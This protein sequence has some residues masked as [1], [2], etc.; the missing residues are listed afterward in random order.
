MCWILLVVH[1]VWAVGKS[2]TP[3]KAN[4]VEKRNY[5]KIYFAQRCTWA[6]HQRNF[7]DSSSFP[8]LPH[9]SP[10]AIQMMNLTYSPP[11]GYHLLVFWRSNLQPFEKWNNKEISRI[12]S[13][14]GAFLIPRGVGVLYRSY[15]FDLI[16]SPIWPRSVGRDRNN[17][18]FWVAGGEHPRN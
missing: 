10:N 12:R 6:R 7:E 14:L 13:N 5:S 17:W 4:L 15:I 1:A 11:H 8:N 9:L 3:Y 2:S 18:D 16:C